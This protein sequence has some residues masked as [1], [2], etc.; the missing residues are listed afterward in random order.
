MQKCKARYGMSYYGW[1]NFLEF[2][3]NKMVLTT[4]VEKLY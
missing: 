2:E 4:K 1:V 3:F